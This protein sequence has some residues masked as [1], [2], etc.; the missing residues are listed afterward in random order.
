MFKEL[1]DTR[2]YF[3][4]LTRI[5]R[6]KGFVT[7]FKHE[8]LSTFCYLPE[9]I[10]NFFDR[11]DLVGTY[12]IEPCEFGINHKRRLIREDIIRRRERQL[13]FILGIPE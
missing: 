4:N 10:A 6:K 5:Y 7:A 8:L 2:T 13:S 11:F 1:A 3:S 9:R 12:F